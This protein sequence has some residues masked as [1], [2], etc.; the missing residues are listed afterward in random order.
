MNKRRGN[1]YVEGALEGLREAC[2]AALCIAGV[3]AAGAAVGFLTV[4]IF[5]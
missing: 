4:T 2:L 3:V 1:P 5:G